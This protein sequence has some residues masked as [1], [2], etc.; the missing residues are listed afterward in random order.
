MFFKD[1]PTLATIALAPAAPIAVPASG[2]ARKIAMTYNRIG[3]LIGALARQTKIPIEGV[4]AVW[5]VESGGEPYVVGRPVARFEVHKFFEHWGKKN[6]AKFDLHFQFGGHAGVAGRVWENHRWRANAGDVWQRFHGDQDAEYAVLEL[7][8]RLGGEAAYLSSS[9]GGPQI[10]GSNCGRVGYASAKA[11]FTALAADERWEVLSFFDF[12]KSG[13]LLDEIAGQRW[14]DLAVGYNGAGKAGAY[15]KDIEA[16][17]NAAIKLP[18]PAAPGHAPGGAAAPVAPAVAASPPVPVPPPG[19]LVADPD[20]NSDFV[21]YISALK[22]RYFKPYE[23][24][25]L[26]SAHSNPSSPAYGLNQLPPRALW[27]NIVPTIRVLDELRNLLGSPIAISNAYRA[28][29]YNA[30]VGGEEYSQ[31]LRFTAIDFVVRSVSTPADWARVL[32]D[33]RSRGMFSGGIGTYATFVHL[34]TRGTNADW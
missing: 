3:G 33:M 25:I 23:L 27:P 8:D 31:H 32:R 5:Q 10:L 26:G 28:P 13:S 20:Y 1:D 19:D 7:A 22:L 9:F 4:L 16:A 18:I 24:L 6:L 34:D 17:F 29:A 14:H 30:A 15:G 12:C 11:F 2:A 21:A